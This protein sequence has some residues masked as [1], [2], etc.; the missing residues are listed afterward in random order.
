MRTVASLEQMMPKH[1]EE[2]KAF[3][4]LRDQGMGQDM[5][6]II[7]ELDRET[8]NPYAINDI[9]DE[10]IYSFVTQLETIVRQNNDILN[11][12]SIV[13]VVQ[14]VNP[15]PNIEELSQIYS[16][17]ELKPLF[18]SFMNSDYSSTLII[19]STDISADDTRMNLL[20]KRLKKD[21]ESAGTP[22]GVVVK[23]TGTPI[24][25]QKLGELISSD[26]T[27][28]QWIS[29]FAVFLITMILFG[30]FSSAL[31]PILVVTLS[32]NWLYGTMGYTGLPI[33]T[34]AGGVAAMVIGIGIDY[35]IHLMNKFKFERKKGLSIKDA[36]EEAVVDS[37]AAIMGAAFS[38]IFAFLA[39][40]F[41]LMPEMGRFGLLMAI[42]VFFSLLITLFGLPAMLILEERLIQLIRKKISFGVEG[43][44]H[45][46]KKGEVHPDGFEEVCLI[47][48][49]LKESIEKKYKVVRKKK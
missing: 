7:I 45:L 35:A 3:N 19:A 1:I 15:S 48:N 40:L 20:A 2:I 32:V 47:D 39:F 22:P 9:R 34:L 24:I 25:Q 5:I 6:G 38:T 17:E 16:N 41:G 42:G 28:T 29:T 18:T 12:F 21:I 8:S 33:S 36:I 4:A 23:L 37:G 46:F 43:E 27:S 10:E 44:Y 11:T 26:R 13:G 14:S 49:E 31:V 30:T